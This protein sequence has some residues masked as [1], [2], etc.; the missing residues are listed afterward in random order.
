M[1]LLSVFLSSLNLFL[2]HLLRDIYKLIGTKEVTLRQ[3]K[4][5]RGHGLLPRS[6]EALLTC[7]HD[8]IFILV[9]HVQ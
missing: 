2:K 7:E 4:P 9:S 6:E 3:R 5:G 1:V 8:E